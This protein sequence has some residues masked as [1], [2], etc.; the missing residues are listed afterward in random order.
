VNEKAR[1]TAGSQTPA[2][3]STATVAQSSDNQTNVYAGRDQAEESADR[4]WWSTAMQAVES[5]AATGRV[6]Q[7]HEVATEF[8][9]Q[10]PDNPRCR[11]GALAAA[12]HR[13]G[14]IAPVGVTESTRPTAARS[15]VRT[16]AGVSR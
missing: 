10:D 8:A 9:L 6:F 14:I 11:W 3:K 5:M 4:W 7:M 2:K 15:L 16:W 13:L 12:C 1:L